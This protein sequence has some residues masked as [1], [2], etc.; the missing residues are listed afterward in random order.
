M[1]S[2]AEIEF[3]S[4]VKSPTKSVITFCLSLQDGQLNASEMQWEKKRIQT[5]N[6]RYAERR[7]VMSQFR[8]P[9]NA[10]STRQ[11]SGHLVW[12]RYWRIGENICGG[13][14]GRRKRRPGRTTR[15]AGRRAGKRKRMYICR[16]SERIKT[17]RI[18]N[19]FP[20]QSVDHRGNVDSYMCSLS[21]SPL[22]FSLSLT[23]WIFSNFSALSFRI[24]RQTKRYAEISERSIIDK[25]YFKVLF[26]CETKRMNKI[27]NGKSDRWLLI[28]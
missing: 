19:G 28:N 8:T 22:P 26:E 14:G 13:D 18:A 24:E 16:L 9:E 2:I 20:F 27:S 17:E 21:S 4:Y 5:K 6:R 23:N 7:K 11:H 1:A 12:V 3:D 10:V 25:T 15:L